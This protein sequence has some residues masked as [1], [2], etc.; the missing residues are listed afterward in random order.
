MNNLGVSMWEFTIKIKTPEN[1]EIE[2][3]LAGIGNRFA[4]VLVDYLIIGLI[5]VL[6][7]AIIATVGIIFEDTFESLSNY[8]ISFLFIGVFFLNFNGYFIIFEYFWSGQTPGKR[9]LG[10]RVIRENGQAVGF[11]EVFIRNILRIVDLI[12]GPYFVLFSKKEKRL[13]DYPI[14]TIVVKE[15]DVSVPIIDTVVPPDFNADIPNISKLSPKDFILIGNYLKRKDGFEQ[16]A[17]ENL[18][19]EFLN[20]YF[21]KL[22]LKNVYNI[23]SINDINYEE[24]LT[25]LIDIYNAYK[26]RGNIN[27]S[28]GGIN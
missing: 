24:K 19:N 28:A 5:T 14:G 21:A 7:Y 16:S 11:L 12:L 1:T 23:E 3:E 2:F 8:I 20:F 6:M 17:R 27:P 10:I 9:L 18:L 26:V 22:S 4:A 15:K 13:G 25:W